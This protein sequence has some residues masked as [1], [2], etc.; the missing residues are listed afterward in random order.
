M[1]SFKLEIL[2]CDQLTSVPL[3]MQTSEHLACILQ[4]FC[5]D[6]NC[7]FITS[8]VHSNVKDLGLGASLDNLVLDHSCPIVAGNVGLVLPVKH[9]PHLETA[10]GRGNCGGGDIL[11]AGEGT[12]CQ[13]GP[14]AWVVGTCGQ[15]LE[16]VF[17]PLDT[18]DMVGDMGGEG[19]ETGE[20]GTE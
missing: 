3:S 4:A 5:L 20:E 11:A 6:V 8:S 2:C 19:P 13:P 17:G 16:G 7:S 12:P 9:L 1:I 18:G 15:G 14:M 10:G